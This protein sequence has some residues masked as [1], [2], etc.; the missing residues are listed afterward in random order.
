M[1][2]NNHS[3]NENDRPSADSLWAKF[4]DQQGR[5]RPSTSDGSEPAEQVEL[6]SELL[7]DL[8]LEGQL[9]MLGKISS[10]DDSFVKNI[11]AQTLSESNPVESSSRLSVIEPAFV[12]KTSETI[13]ESNLASPTDDLVDSPPASSSKLTHRQTVFRLATLAA[14]LIICCFAG[15]IWWF[16]GDPEIADSPNPSSGVSSPE[17]VPAIPDQPNGSEKDLP[18]LVRESDVEDKNHFIDDHADG[19]LAGKSDGD[20]SS[21]DPNSGIDPLAALI[22]EIDYPIADSNPTLVE[23]K[24]DLRPLD[25][26]E[27]PKDQT[28]LVPGP[29]GLPWDSKFNWNLAIQFGSNGL[30]KVA[31]NGEPVKAIFLQDNAVFL[32][33]QIA[34]ELGRRVEFLDNRLG[35][36]ISG[37]IQV[38]ES[39][40]DFVHVSEL[41][42]TVD[43]VDKHIASLNIRSL[44]VDELMGLRVR[45]RKGIGLNRGKFR[46]INLANKDLRFYTE[47]EA[48]AICSVLSDSEAILRDLA[49]KRLDWEKN[50]DVV[51]AESKLVDRV[52]PKAFR[53]FADSGPLLLPDPDL[54]A[55]SIASIQKL[56]PSELSNML[57]NAPSV[58]MFRHFLEFQQAKDF[59]F[60]NGPPEMKMRLSIDKIDRK[61]ESRFGSRADSSLSDSES[62]EKSALISQKSRLTTEL[63]RMAVSIP[64]DSEAMQP[65]MDLVAKRPDLQS[66]PFVM[67]QE[68]H[69]D[70]TETSDLRNVSLSLGR[71]IGRFNGSLGSRDVAQNDAF[72]NLSIK[73]MISYC[74]ED[75]IRDRMGDPE[76]DPSAQKM[77]TI[78]QILQIDHPRLRMNFIDALR[79]SDSETAVELMVKKAKFDL[80]PE[81]RI[82]A[83]D[84]LADIEPEQYRA[85]L[86]EG[87]KYPWH[88][89][90]E[91]S[92]EALVRLDDEGA[93]PDLIEMLDLPHPHSPTQVDGQ[94]VQRE[95]VGINHMRNCLLCHAPSISS[96]DS[97]RGLIPHS[98][99][100]IPT[101]YYGGSSEPVPYAVRADI[102]YLEQDFSV[103]QPVSNP[104]PWP[105]E[106]RFD[107]VVQNRKLSADE[108]SN[109][110]V[111]LSQAPNQNRNA[112]IFALRELTGE[113][114]VDNSSAN[115][116]KIMSDR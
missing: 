77:K 10:P 18:K 31:L 50:T 90:A 116:K 28:D 48:F 92:A 97:T 49:K 30:G 58:E 13:S 9:R 75:H 68:C 40:Y 91:H 113:K 104:G 53:H 93:I 27:I 25:T 78:D 110:A 11:T 12:T 62:F 6:T 64:G 82:A 21:I 34:S 98:S 7:D 101:Q 45:Y 83:T 19:T 43:K 14:A 112:I 39:K 108:A 107:Y 88:V 72:R 63:R 54:S 103:V 65:L 84:A 26:E 23:T 67:G 81:V 2:D 24:P 66:L 87:L 3:Q 47:D 85:H 76:G 79:K 60:S 20:K 17:G 94:L 36:E 56:G 71:M 37:S 102:T 59:V 46:S 100:P 35:S 95:L 70:A 44:N 106:Q 52:K 86:L 80:V 29:N 41:D 105:H 114:P 61:L 32:L 109:L 69:S 33:R 1:S 42:E 22:E 115:W 16:A 55:Q 73:Q 99:R 57:Q 5:S 51:P 8:E 38:G 89:V 4:V 111:G 15:S 74:M 96:E